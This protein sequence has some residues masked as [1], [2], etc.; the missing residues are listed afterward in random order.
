MQ[1]SIRRCFVILVSLSMV[2]SICFGLGGQN[3]GAKELFYDPRGDGEVLAVGPTSD[4]ETSDV[5]RVSES[6]RECD[7][8]PV[9]DPAEKHLGLSYWIELLE[10][11]DAP[12]RQVTESRIFK[13]GE[14][15]RLHFLSN[16]D[17]LISLL[18][19]GS[20]GRP[21][22]LFPD[23]A[24]GLDDNYLRAGVER[25]LPT[26]GAWFRFDDTVGT[27]KLL[28]V[29]ASEQDQL[30]TMLYEQPRSSSPRSDLVRLASAA[31][32]SKDLFVETETTN[33]AEIGTYA[34]NVA[35]QPIV[36]EIT[37]KHE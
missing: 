3:R 34:V 29:F 6:P 7:R 21:T 22:F 20:S 1:Q 36:L 5:T 2:G 10:Q 19:I 16:H 24:K 15:I 30:E 11:P 23:P 35:G 25:I 37:L 31:S 26:R 9:V 4:C 12:G 8:R 13:S 32:G 27:E 28:V 17:G 14:A 18:Q 33:A